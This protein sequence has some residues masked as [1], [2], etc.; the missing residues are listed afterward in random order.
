MWESE[1]RSFDSG[2]TI[3]HFNDEHRPEMGDEHVF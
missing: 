3:S 1:K 2:S